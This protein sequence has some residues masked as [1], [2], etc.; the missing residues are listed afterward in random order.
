MS[1]SDAAKARAEAKFKRKEEQVRDGTQAWDEY[2]ADRHA[3]TENTKRLR[4]LRLARDA[5]AA[6]QSQAV[7]PASAAP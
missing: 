5:A 2:E 1:V 6:A 7:Q 3:V 4:A